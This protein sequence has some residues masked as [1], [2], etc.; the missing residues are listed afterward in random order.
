MHRLHRLLMTW[1]YKAAP[2]FWAVSGGPSDHW[3]A[4][5]RAGTLLYAARRQPESFRL[6]EQAVLGI[7]PHFSVAPDAAAT[8]EQLG[9]PMAPSLER[10]F[11]AAGPLPVAAEARC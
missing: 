9:H 2:H 8:A 3:K 4:A 5:D 11:A 1:Q 6:Q 7:R 10:A